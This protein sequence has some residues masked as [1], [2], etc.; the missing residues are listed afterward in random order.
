MVRMVLQPHE[1]S[2][3][4]HHWRNPPRERSIPREQREIEGRGSDHKYSTKLSVHYTGLTFGYDFNRRLGELD[5]KEL[6]LM[7]AAPLA[8]PPKA[9]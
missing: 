6:S 9:D 4:A 3:F 1:T 2:V 5:T 7:S 8:G